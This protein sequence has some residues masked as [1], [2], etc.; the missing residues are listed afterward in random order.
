M[1]YNQLNAMQGAI[2]ATSVTPGAEPVPVSNPA[3]IRAQKLK[4]D[5]NRYVDWLD[6][7]GV[8]GSSQLDAGTGAGNLGIKYVNQYKKE[9]PD[10]LISPETIKEVQG[11]MNNY[12]ESTIQ[13]LRDK[14]AQIS[15]AKA[16]GGSRFVSP[17]ENL[18][19]YMKNL[20]VNDGVPGQQTTAWKFPDEFLKT[21]YRGPG[22][23]VEKVTVENQ[24]LASTQKSTR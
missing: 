18:D 4:T 19:Y 10:S 1:N 3:E 11:H 12:R 7:K 8:K 14:K 21:T 22:K 15:D 2:P 16:P 23:K 20:S 9:N 13:Q 24:G 17:D 6:Q 5:W